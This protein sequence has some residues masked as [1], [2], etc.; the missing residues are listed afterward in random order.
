V[1]SDNE[2]D[3]EHN[4]HEIERSESFPP[5]SK[6]I[7]NRRE[8]HLSSSIKTNRF[9]N[10]DADSIGLEITE[11]VTISQKH[12]DHRDNI[13]HKSS[14]NTNSEPTQSS[15]RHGTS[16]YLSPRRSPPPPPPPPPAFAKSF[17]QTQQHGVQ[18]ESEPFVLFVLFLINHIYI[19]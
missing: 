14:I 19:I 4:I 18:E 15:E 12:S 8:N 7:L 17:L 5:Y 16:I 6:P 10:S 3:N 9:K 11:P 13:R 2:M 1:N